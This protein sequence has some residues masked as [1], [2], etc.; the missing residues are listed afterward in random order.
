MDPRDVGHPCSP[1]REVTLF[2]EFAGEHADSGN[3]PS[4]QVYAVTHGAGSTATSM[5]VGRDH[6]L[7]VGCD[8]AEHLII[9]ADRSV[10]LS[11]V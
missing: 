11:E 6:R 3:A 1:S 7:A 4:G 5:A 8:C 10:A 9:C 2:V